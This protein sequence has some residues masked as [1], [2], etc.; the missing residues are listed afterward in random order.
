MF[1][2]DIKPFSGFAVPDLAAAKAFY[3][4]TLGLSVTEENGLLEL[5]VPGER[6]TLI[7]EK[8]DHEPAVFTIL[9]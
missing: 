4:D 7:Y 6:S 1:P 8:A 5:E 3:A 9:N 2:D